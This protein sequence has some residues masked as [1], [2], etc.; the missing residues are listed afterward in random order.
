MKRS[1]RA[2][3]DDVVHMIEKYMSL[4]KN[5][6]V[7]FNGSKI[8]QNVESLINQLNKVDTVTSRFEI[9]QFN[10]LIGWT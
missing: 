8:K 1:Y 4:V 10:L 9:G 3:L 5:F 7:T 2:I 6:P